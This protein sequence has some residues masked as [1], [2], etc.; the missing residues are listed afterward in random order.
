LRLEA[1]IAVIR[2]L[3]VKLENDAAR[4]PS[5]DFATSIAVMFDAHVAG[6]AF[7]NDPVLPGYVLAELPQD[8]VEQQRQE[9]KRAAQ[10][11]IERFDAAAKRNQLSA[12][13][14]LHEVSAEAAPHLFA[15]IVRRF[16]L[17]VVMQSDPERASNDAVIEAS[18][19]ESG[20]P[21]IVVPY[22][23]KHELKLDRVVCCW[24]GGRPAARAINDA[25]PFL[26][27]ARAVELLSV[28]IEKTADAQRDFGEEMARHLARHRINVEIKSVAAPEADVTDT[29]VAHVGNTRATMVVMGAFGHSR[30]REFVLGG[31]TVGM[32]ASM[33]V[34]VLMSH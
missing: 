31:V 17:S 9:R 8:I 23:Q 21:A 30:L 1:R 3:V 12:E 27:K 33:S 22:T 2:D 34:P 4:D 6:V 18:L 13:H 26:S 7:T 25:L 19:F 15:A 29:I 20:R 11:A 14:R 24:D 32:L 10:G 28:A 5:G 16:D